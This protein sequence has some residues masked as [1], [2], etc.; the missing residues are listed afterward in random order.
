MYIIYHCVGGAHSSVIACA[1]HLGTLPID[2]TPSKEEVL[3]VPYFDTLNK[4]DQG[5]IILRGIDKNNNKV[6]SLSR[7]F[8]PE[9]VIPAVKDA[10]ELGGGHRDELLLVNTMP[11]VNSLMKIGGFSSRRLNLVS[12][13]RPIVASGVVK[14]YDSIVNIVKNT[15]NMM[16]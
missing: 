10:F 5:K 2:R 16:S 6:F 15:K 3:N 11:C 12:F 8:K 14:N 13:G 9:L 1:I 4:Q 7:Q